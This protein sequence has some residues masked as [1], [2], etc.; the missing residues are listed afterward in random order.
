VAASTKSR[1]PERISWDLDKN[2]YYDRTDG[3]VGG[4]SELQ[5]NINFQWS[6]KGNGLSPGVIKSAFSQGTRRLVEPSIIYHL[7]ETATLSLAPL[8]LHYP[9]KRVPSPW[10]ATGADHHFTISGE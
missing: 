9:A 8:R 1:I 4:I 2:I 10:L 7:S 5:G 3:E 6:L